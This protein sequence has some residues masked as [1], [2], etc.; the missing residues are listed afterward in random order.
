MRGW[1]IGLAA[2]AALVAW[3][4]WSDRNSDI[5]E[6]RIPLAEQ[7][8]ASFANAL[9]RVEFNPQG[10]AVSRLQ[11]EQMLEYGQ[12]QQLELHQLRWYSLDP[13]D[14][15]SIQA[16]RGQQL[17]DQENLFTGQVIAQRQNLAG[18]IYWLFSEEILHN[19]ASNSLSSP[20]K[21]RLELGN[22]YITGSQMLLDMDQN[23]LIFEQHQ[24][25]YYAPTSPMP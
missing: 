19:S 13:E 24:E 9:V 16:Q 14:P 18:E 6:S 2:I 12:S 15:W 5:I 25:S 23:T 4:G 3:F 22:N 1:L 11:A 10:Q 8:L 21:A 7:Q 20:V 17:S